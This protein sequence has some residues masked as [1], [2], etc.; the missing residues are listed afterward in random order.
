M[1]ENDPIYNR[2]SDQWM[3][4]FSFQKRYGVRYLSGNRPWRLFENPDF[5]VAELLDTQGDTRKLNQVLDVQIVKILRAE[6]W[7]YRLRFYRRFASACCRY[8]EQAWKN[9]VHTRWNK[10]AKKAVEFT[11]ANQP[12]VEGRFA[13]EKPEATTPHEA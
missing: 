4:G 9:Q 10:A 8:V 7:A 1:L 2:H 5:Y 3:E 11:D 6:R 13:P 12:P